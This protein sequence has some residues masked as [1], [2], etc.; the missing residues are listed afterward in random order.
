MKMLRNSQSM[1][2]LGAVRLM[3]YEFEDL[4][5]LVSETPLGTKVE[6]SPKLAFCLYKVSENLGQ[7]I[8][9]GTDADRLEKIWCFATWLLYLGIQMGE[10]KRK[11]LSLVPVNSEK[12]H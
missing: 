2:Q 8:D 7:L 9:E 12:V 1:R 10:S 6:L 5:K 11:P 4:Q 3:D